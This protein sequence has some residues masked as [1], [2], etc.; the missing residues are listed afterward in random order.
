MKTV[1]QSS[2]LPHEFGF[3]LIAAVAVISLGRRALDVVEWL[4]AHL[5][6]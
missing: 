2:A 1:P 4:S 3:L 6:F 5:P